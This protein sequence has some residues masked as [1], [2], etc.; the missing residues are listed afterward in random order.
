MYDARS[1][2]NEFVADSLAEAI[3]KAC[4]FFDVEESDLTV[5]EPPSGDIFGLGSRYAIVA[6]PASVVPR[7]PGGG[8]ADGGDRSDRGGDRGR[9]RDR[10][11][12]DRDRGRGRER[13]GRGERGGS[14]RGGN[15]REE[16]S[17]ASDDSQEQAA[18]RPE[19]QESTGSAVGEITAVGEYLLGVVERMAL[20]S[21]ELKEVEEDDYLVL[22]IRG[23]AAEALGAEHTRAIGALQL[24]VNQAALQ[25]DESPKRIVI[26]CGESNDGRESLLERAADR[27]ARRAIE[28]GRPVALDPMNGHDRRLVHV[29]VRETEGVATMS[30][31]T[32]RYRQVVIVPEGAPEYEEALEASQGAAERG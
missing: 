11:P 20:G 28:T 4:R 15:R 25:A 18:K 21:F 5:R 12:R 17:E 1:E 6:F 26:D 30:H 23:V 3:A 29:A 31:G 32:G 13:G 19:P 10:G 14:G 9:G 27:A 7:R 24:L 16:R 8:G 22:E 2:P